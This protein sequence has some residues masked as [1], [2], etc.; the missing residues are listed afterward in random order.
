MKSPNFEDGAL[1]MLARTKVTI[2]RVF[3]WSTLSLFGNSLLARFVVL[4]PIVALYVRL[5]EDYLKTT[6]GLTYAF[7]LYWSLI[8]ISFG[9]LVFMLA[10]PVLIKKYGRD[11]ERFK[12]EDFS[13]R[14]EKDRSEI[15]R[16]QIRS[17]FVPFG[18]PL[19]PMLYP[20]S[21]AAQTQLTALNTGDMASKGSKLFSFLNTFLKPGEDNNLSAVNDV[22]FIVKKAP[23]ALASNSET[24]KAKR[25]LSELAIVLDAAAS[26]AVAQG[27]RR[28]Q[29]ILALSWHFSSTDRSRLWAR[30]IV[31]FL[32]AG[33]SL[34]F[35]WSAARG[36]WTMLG[37]S[38]SGFLPH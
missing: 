32:Y 7:W 10:C 33:G 30:V 27:G 35:L 21:A 6:F 4:T 31:G 13:S 15:A 1:F 25:A 34:Y 28:E 8:A 11:S 9:Q 36:I 2:E 14:S 18:G 19:K 16:R 26:D 20:T 3:H 22:R 17:F 29:S 38:L 5:Q 24:P 37:Y 23:T 12:V